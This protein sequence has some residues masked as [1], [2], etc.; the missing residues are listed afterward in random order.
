MIYPDLSLSLVTCIPT[1]VIIQATEQF[2]QT[3]SSTLLP[4]P[5]PPPPLYFPLMQYL[6]YPYTHTHQLHLV[7][8][9]PFHC[10]PPSHLFPVYC[11]TYYLNT[12]I[13]A[14]I[15]HTPLSPQSA[16]CIPLDPP[17]HYIHYYLLT[18][19]LLFYSRYQ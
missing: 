4:P 11:H 13:N 6:N 17:I 10:S 12:V 15:A 1:L 16:S 14:T 19:H 3:F 9:L 5:P 8:H 2:K 7:K 18:H